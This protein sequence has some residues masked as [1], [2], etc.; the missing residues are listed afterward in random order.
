MAQSKISHSGIVT[1]VDG[2][3][4]FVKIEVKSA[5][6]ACHAKGLCSAADMAEKIIETV[7]D[8]QLQTGDSVI[9]EMD[10]KLGF[11]AVFF[12][13]VIPFILLVT[14]LFAAWNITGSE[15][16]AAVASI[17]VLVPYYFGLVLFKTYFKKNFV[18][19]CRKI[20]N[21]SQ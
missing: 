14:A 7:S 13:F 6:S 9:V 16:V 15:T 1:S 5:C 3:T 17:T 12:T 18:F 2:K 20:S 4:A 8:E 10:E 21:I 19:T 11:K